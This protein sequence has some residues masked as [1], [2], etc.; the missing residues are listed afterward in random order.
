MSVSRRDFFRVSGTVAA[1]T[2]VGALAGLGA[3]LRPKVALARDLR[4]K[5]GSA[6]DRIA[7]PPVHRSLRISAVLR[8]LGVDVL[9]RH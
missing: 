8:R 1:G 5:D 9:E 4:I 3:D 6:V 2:A 7:H